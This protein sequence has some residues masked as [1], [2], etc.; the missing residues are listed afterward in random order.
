MDTLTAMRAF[1][2]VAAAGSFTAGAE[3]LGLATNLASKY[4]GQLETRLG[5]R[6][7]NR[8]TRRVSLTE[9]GR[10][11]L[12]RCTGL[13]EEFDTLE[14]AVQ[15]RQARP[16][17]TL[18]MAAPVTF[19]E[20]YL[21]PA[22]ADFMEAEPGVS[23]DLRLSDR[24][25]NLVDE[26]FDLAIR[27]A[28]LQ[29]SSLI[30]K[31]L[32]PARIVACAS[33]D[34]LRRAGAPQH[35]AELAAHACIIDTNFRAGPVWPFLVEG[36]RI[37]VKVSGRFAVNSGEAIRALV[38]R[39]AGVALCPAYIVGEDIKAGRLVPILAS[40]EAFALGVYAV[41]PH[42]RHLAA[43]VRAAID[44]LA[45]RFAAPQWDGA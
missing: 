30:A 26:G 45:R 22:L 43:K 35:P 37:T 3:K 23:I 24:F 42:N 34:Y 13:L 14:A 32:A 36:E 10:A 27:I 17:G 9:A 39:G 44:F 41:Y 16:S 12:E 15:D 29:D 18:T 21:A 25:V 8:T 1:T 2:A 5:V 6:L 19:G 11:Y 33:L 4:V 31:R 38:L 7:L 20:K 28:E 40:F